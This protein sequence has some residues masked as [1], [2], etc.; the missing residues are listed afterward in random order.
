MKFHIPSIFSIASF[1]L[2]GL[3]VATAFLTA[4]W[5]RF[6]SGIFSVGSITHYPHFRSFVIL[7]VVLHWTVFKYFG[8]YRKRRGISG[9]DELSKIIKGVLVANILVGAATFL[10][11]FVEFS[12]LVAGLLV[13][14]ASFLVW[15]ERLALRRIQVSMRRRGIGVTRVL[16]VGTGETALV[17]LRR[18]KQN[19]GLG[20]RVVGLVSEG[21]S[22]RPV[23]SNRILGPLQKF[24]QILK[25]QSTHICLDIHTHTYVHTYIA[26][27]HTVTVCTLLRTR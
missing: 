13:I 10:T 20:Y 25:G 7:V 6:H 27:T 26:H 15:A 4:N 22:A 5:L 17:L 19:P 2:D 14:L 3:E 16:I 18:L 9:V 24:N 21:K 11:H 12:R 23:E 8:L 1:V